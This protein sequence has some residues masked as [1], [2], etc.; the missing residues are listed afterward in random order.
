[1]KFAASICLCVFTLAAAQSARETFDAA[2]RALASGDSEAAER[3]FQ[4]VL[5]QEPR[6]IAA[7]SNLGVIYSRTSRADQAIA[8]YQRALAVSPNEQA[9]LLNLGLVYLRQEDHAKALP[10][11]TRVA[12]MD[13]RN[14]QARQLVAVCR[15]Y[16][17]Q[18]EPAIQELEAL[19]A[20]AP[21]DDGILFLLGFAYLK[22]HDA[23]K[24]KVVFQ[25]MFDAAGPVKAQFLMGRANYEAILFPQAEENFR[26]VLRLDPQF[27]GVHLELGKLYICL[28]QT[29]DAIR[30]LQLAEKDTPGDA[31]YFLGA[32]LVQ[33]GRFDEG[34]PYLEK[35]KTAKPDFWAPFFYLGKAKLR[36]EKPAEAVPLLRRAAALNPA[37]EVSVYY[38]LGKALEACGRTAEAHAALARVRDLRAAAAEAATLDGHV[39]GAH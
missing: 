6:N 31:D 4:A 27:P 35:A 30:E 26:E 37:D 17:G 16:L 28:R 20:A 10:L 33:E 7:L 13:P 18:L 21:K 19:H 38:Q 22:N 8:M 36:M 15:T 24:A 34:I 2:A 39:A 12:E 32:L 14:M 29:G 9:V 1:M 23:E 5:R 25:D 11:F 3:G